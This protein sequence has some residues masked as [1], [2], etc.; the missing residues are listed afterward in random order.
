MSKLGCELPDFWGAMEDAVIDK[1]ASAKSVDLSMIAWAFGHAEKG[2]RAINDVARAAI[3]LLDELTPQ[4]LANTAWAAARLEAPNTELCRAIVR[5]SLSTVGEFADFDVTHLCWALA[6][7]DAVDTE[8]FDRLADH[9]VSSGFIR[10]FSSQMASQLAWAFAV[11]RVRHPALFDELAA[12]V[13][14]HAHVLEP[15]YLASCAWA[16]ASVSLC[17]PSLVQALTSVSKGG[18]LWSFQPSE[19]CAL[20]WAFAKLGVKDE[21]GDF[22]G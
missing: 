5:K 6:K 12:Y 9:T 22:I 21:E 15:R 16:F 2:G 18:K 3:G 20:S 7:L 14:K 17:H 8:L 13:A 11:G 19:F 1:I 4:C 10:R